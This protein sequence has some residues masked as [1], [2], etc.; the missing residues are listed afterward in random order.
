MSEHTAT[1]RVHVT[2]RAGRDEVT[3]FADG[4]LRVRVSAPPVDGRANEA[5]ERLIAGALALPP[6]AVRV[7]RGHRTRHKTVVV[8]GMKSSEVVAALGGANSS[9]AP[10]E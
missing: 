3:G 1:I 8:A 9:S 5:V 10:A 7:V 6:S 2:P 4:V